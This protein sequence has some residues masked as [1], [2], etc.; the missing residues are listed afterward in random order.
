MATI[1]V[2]YDGSRAA[3]AALSRVAEIVREDDAVIVVGPVERRWTGQRLTLD[4]VDLE[5]GGRRLDEARR[6]LFAAGVGARTVMAVGEPWRV[7]ARTAA[8]VDARL[9]VTGRSRLTPRRLG[10]DRARRLSRLAACPVEV[11]AG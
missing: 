7:V 11:V 8:A 4:D 10:V 2:G 6:L 9:V 1:V 3:R 5:L